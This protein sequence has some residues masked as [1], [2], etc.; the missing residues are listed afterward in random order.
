MGG[1]EWVTA[2]P[3]VC[4]WQRLSS[5]STPKFAWRTN[6]KWIFY[7]TPTISRPLIKP[8][9]SFIWKMT[10]PLGSAKPLLLLCELWGWSG[11]ML[12]NTAG[13]QRM[14]K[15][16]L[17]KRQ[18]I[19]GLLILNSLEQTHSQASALSYFHTHKNK[20]SEIWQT[21]T[22]ETQGR[23]RSWPKG[24]CLSAFLTS[25]SLSSKVWEARKV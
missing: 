14:L 18:L 25:F 20:N 23:D 11:A 3:F 22:T 13:A 12:T 6:W 8:G 2:G 7:Y 21:Q 24:E 19:T 4:L 15:R 5:F 17:R 9:P 16:W 1:L 10:F